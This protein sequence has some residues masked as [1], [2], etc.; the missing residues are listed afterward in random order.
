MRKKTKHCEFKNIRFSTRKESEKMKFQALKCIRLHKH[1]LASNCLTPIAPNPRAIFETYAP[2]RNKLLVRLA[3]TFFFCGKATW[4]C[5]FSFSQWPDLSSSARIA[6][7]LSISGLLFAKGSK[8]FWRKK[9]RFL[10]FIENECGNTQTH[11]KCG[12]LK[13]RHT[14]VGWLKNG[15]HAHRSKI[16][17]IETNRLCA[18]NL[19]AI[20]VPVIVCVW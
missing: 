13:M 12:I 18:L 4:N 16:F 11:K 9:K 17:N 5:A 1:V 6:A 20:S 8:C 10:A 15:Y 2:T 3:H 14:I 7:I 19:F